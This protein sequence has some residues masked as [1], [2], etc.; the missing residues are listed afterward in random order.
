[1]RCIKRQGPI[2][3]NKLFAASLKDLSPRTNNLQD[4]GA[5]GAVA[6]SGALVGNQR[7][8]ADAEAANGPDP[9][10]RRGF[11][12]G[13]PSRTANGTSSAPANGNAEDMENGEVG[14][15]AQR[16]SDG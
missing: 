11:S 10:I 9:S 5:G 4:R 2:T 1:M 14:K 12:H 3:K 8:T 15:D 16:Q 13:A 7:A 6:E